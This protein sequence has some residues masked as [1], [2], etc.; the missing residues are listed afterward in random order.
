MSQLAMT[1]SDNAASDDNDSEEDM[2]LPSNPAIDILNLI[3]NF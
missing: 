1:A 2:P 3:G